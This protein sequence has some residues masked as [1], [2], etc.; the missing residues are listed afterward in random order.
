MCFL[1]ADPADNRCSHCN[2][3]YFC[4]DEHAAL[5]RPKKLCFPFKIQFDPRVGRYMVATRDIEPLGKT[6]KY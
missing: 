6:I 1:C 3:A 4:S 2:L 5:L